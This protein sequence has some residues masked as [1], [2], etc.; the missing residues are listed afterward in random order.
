[1]ATSLVPRRKSRRSARRLSA[2][3]VVVVAFFS[4]GSNAR[5]QDPP[6]TAGPVTPRVELRHDLRLDVPIT[7]GM[8]A[9]VVT[10]TLVKNDVV[11]AGTTIGFVVGGGVPWLFHQPRTTA[12]S[13]LGRILQRTRLATTEVRGGRIVTLGA[14]F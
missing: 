12:T 2:Q 8:A 10:W 3:A 4:G 9:G 13:E 6:G 7:I 1:M 5:A 14:S 11:L